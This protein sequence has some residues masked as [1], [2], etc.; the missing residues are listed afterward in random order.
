MNRPLAS[1]LR[2]RRRTLLASAGALA[3]GLA[4]LPAPAQTAYP[5]RPVRL[6]VPF[7]A[8]GATDAAARELGEGLSKLLGQPFVVENRPGADGAIAAHAVLDAPA[9]GYTLFFASSS[10]EGVPLVQKA[11][12]FKSLT[13]FT[14]V[15]MVCRLVFGVVVNPAVP[16]ATVQDLVAHARANPGKLNYGSGSLSEL[17]AAA[18]FMKATGTRLVRINYRGGAQIVPDL[19]SGQLQVSFGPLTPMLPMLRDKRL[20]ALAL[21]AD[22]RASVAPGAPTLKE[23]GIQGVTGGG[24]LQMVLAPPRLPAEMGERL[25]AAI[26]TVMADPE[27]QR[28]FVQRGQEPQTSTPEA[29]TALLQAER[30]QWMQF[31]AD[32]A[33]KPE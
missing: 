17:M 19:V 24:G 29:L 11:A 10:I 32:E 8:G 33:L 25:A 22:Q 23:A 7:P 26:K 28:K 15:S 31:A 3:L 5:A 14:P 2:P 4:G 16:A 1:R 18:Q 13:D 9:D 20:T 27:V 21:V 30:A 12:Q 6:I